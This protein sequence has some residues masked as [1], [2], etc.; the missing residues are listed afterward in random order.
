MRNA[1]ITMGAQAR[2]G[3]KTI[4][5]NAA[6]LAAPFLPAGI[7]A[8]A[9][10]FFNALRIFLSSAVLNTTVIMPLEGLT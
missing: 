7:D 6:G 9:I 4:K 3:R 8:R 10:Y 1:T 2:S 5:K